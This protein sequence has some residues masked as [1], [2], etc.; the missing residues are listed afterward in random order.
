MHK[1]FIYII[2]QPD[3]KSGTVEAIHSLGYKA[4]LL[5][6]N[7]LKETYDNIFDR[8]I[9]VNFSQLDIELSR[10]SGL[11]DM[12]VAGFLCTYE[13]YITAKAKLGQHF[14]TPSLSI[15]SAELCTDKSLM[16]QAF[17][18]TDASISPAFTTIDSIAAAQTFAQTHG[19]PLIIKPTGLVKSLLVMR[20]NTA[21]EL[22]QNVGYA[23]DTV[24][25][26]YT[27][28][29]IYNR[30]PQ[31]IIEE[32]MEGDQYSIAAFVDEK[33]SPY[34]AEGA[35]SLTTAQDIGKDDT[36][37]YKRQLPADI[38][39]ELLAE[40]LHVSNIGVKALKMQST[41]AHIELMHTPSGVKIIEIGARIGGY[42]PR[43]YK[44]CYDINL[45]QQDIRLAIGKKPELT[46]SLSQHCAVYELFPDKE[47]IFA[48]INGNIDTDELA[49][50][51]ETVPRGSKIGPAKH[52][53]K[54]TV[55]II[56]TS[57]DTDKFLLLCQAVEA[58]SV[59][60]AQ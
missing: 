3:L 9:D 5:R 22:E 55:I 4:G 30:Q 14:H 21:E 40:L 2:G 46:G 20:C 51:R 60:V 59:E 23:L 28:H 24:E 32:C 19:Y 35:I 38:K 50:Y 16:R 31:L 26:L 17:N 44:F 15:E 7:Q 57:P 27:R 18:N 42:R 6:D 13:N 12:Q 25:E 58:L 54:A 47:G 52:G 36:Y 34:F 45:V 1:Q 43:M 49:Y 48:N 11:M 41:A 8:V 33:G 53:Y 39:P 10:L 29:R 56:V 37:L